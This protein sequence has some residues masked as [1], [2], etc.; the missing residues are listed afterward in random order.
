MIFG[1]STSTGGGYTGVCGRSDSPIGNG[2]IGYASA[3]SGT[4]YGVYGQSSSTSGYGV[5]YSGGLAGTGTKPAIVETQ[6]Y[7]WRHS[8]AMECPQNWF[9]GFGQVTLIHGVATVSIEP[10]FAQT[11]TPD[12]GYHVFLTRL[13]QCALYVAVRSLGAFTVRALEGDGC[14]ISFDNRI[15][16]TRPDY[17]DLRLEPA[18]DPDAVAASGAPPLSEPSSP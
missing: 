13:G 1:Y 6:V 7:G 17:E 11:V 14:E 15:V 3:T 8:Y 12:D 4:N 10:I 16:A 9:E 18:Q 5:Y 2:V